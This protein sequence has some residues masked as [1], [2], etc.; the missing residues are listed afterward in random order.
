MVFFLF[1][2]NSNKILCEQT[3]ET[4][5]RRRFLQRLIL[6]CAIRLHVCPTKGTLGLYGLIKQTCFVREFVVFFFHL[7]HRRGKVVI[8]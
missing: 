1:Y 5:I 2:S 6:I 3:V 7:P 4:L 8:S